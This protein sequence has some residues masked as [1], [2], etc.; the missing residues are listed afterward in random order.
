MEKN[1]FKKKNLIIEDEGYLEIYN[2]DYDWA[3][4]NVPNFEVGKINIPY[5]LTMRKKSISPPYFL[6]EAS[7][8][9]NLSCFPIFTITSGILGIPTIELKILRG[10]SSPPKPELIILLQISIITFE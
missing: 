6:T 3:N 4:S 8:P 7:S 10:P 9:T 5:D 2:F 1:F